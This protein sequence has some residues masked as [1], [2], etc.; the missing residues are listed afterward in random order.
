MFGFDNV[1]ACGPVYTKGPTPFDSNGTESFQCVELSER[2][3]WAIYG[4]APIFGSN[5]DGATIV[6]LYHQAH[7]SIEVGTPSPSSLPGPGDVISLGPGGGSDAQFGHTAV[8]VSA[9]SGGKFVIMSQNY[10][11]GTAGEQTLSVDLSGAHNGSVLLG[12]AWTKASWLKLAATTTVVATALIPGSTG[13]YVLKSDGNIAAFGNAPTATPSATWSFSIARRIVVL[14]NGSGGYV[15]EGYGG[16]HPFAIGSNPM[17][18]GTTI[19]AYWKNWDI[20]RGIV[21]LPDGS[22]GYVLDGWGGVHPFAIGSNPMPPGARTSVYWKGWDIAR[23]IVINGAGTGGYVIDG[24]GG[25]HPWAVGS[26]PMPPNVTVTGYWP[27]WDIA[28][29]LVLDFTGVSGYTLEGY[30]GLHPFSAPGVPMPPGIHSPD[31]G[32]V[33]T[34]RGVALYQ[35]KSSAA[36]AGGSVSNIPGGVAGEYVTSDRAA[37]HAFYALA[38]A[39]DIVALPGVS[40]AGYV[41]TGDGGLATVGGAPSATPSGNWPWDIA[42]DAVVLSNGSGGYVLDGYGGVHPFAIGSNPMPPAATT[43][44]Y[45]SGWDIARRLVLLPDGT[46]G[47]VLDGYGG[48]HPWAIGSNPMPPDATYTGYWPG[49]DIARGMVINATGTGGY[50]LD[51]W[52]GVHPWAVGSNAM[53]PAVTTSAY[54]KGWDIARDLVLLPGGKGGQVLDGYGALH[55][56]AVGSNTMPGTPSVSGYFAGWDVVPSVAVVKKKGPLTFD[57]VDSHKGVHPAS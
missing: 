8:V 54:W 51:G 7:P 39:R 26:N 45:W 52:G 28:R 36:E 27:G 16:V 1:W 10:P 55:P 37:P 25:L 3:L 5:V 33:D 14:P 31:Y 29:D 19:G 23:S 22:G 43:K 38:P 49:W 53:P 44:A 20:A 56:F 47:Y 21:V 9:P 15:L 40:G 32:N 18:P 57:T 41:L 46:G 13:G 35:V 4:L 34:A 48:V 6:S 30:G 12:G 42:R 24:Y 50:T 2:F 17:P 11:E